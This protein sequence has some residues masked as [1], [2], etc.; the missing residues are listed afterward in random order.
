MGLVIST[1]ASVSWT[2]M[3]RSLTYEFFKNIW[4]GGGQFEFLQEKENLVTFHRTVDKT[5]IDYKG[6]Y[7]DC[8]LSRMRI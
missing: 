8:W 4:V 7:K 2:I 5:Q 1:E 3:W 6:L